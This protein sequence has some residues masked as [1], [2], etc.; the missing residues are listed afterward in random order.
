MFFMADSV[1]NSNHQAGGLN[2]GAAGDSSAV[3]RLAE[4]VR[5]AIFF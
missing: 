1:F 4:S 2:H 5:R 3:C